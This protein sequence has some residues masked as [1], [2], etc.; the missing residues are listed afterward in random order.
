[1]TKSGYRSCLDVYSTPIRLLDN[2][3][4]YIIGS[5]RGMSQRDYMAYETQENHSRGGLEAVDTI[6]GFIAVRDRGQY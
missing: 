5:Y 1:V 4:Y 6:R 2:M 3:L